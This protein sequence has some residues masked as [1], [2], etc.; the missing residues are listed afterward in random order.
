M[1]PALT[2]HAPRIS[3]KGYKQHLSRWAVKK[4]MKEEMAIAV[5]RQGTNQPIIMQR[6][7][8]YL[9]RLPKDKRDRILRSSQ[10]LDSVTA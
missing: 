5:L 6:T 10:G 2:R 8:A 7:M 3:E 9:N 4:N 1:H